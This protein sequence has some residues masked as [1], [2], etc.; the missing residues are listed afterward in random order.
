MISN[1]DNSH[2]PALLSSNQGA[3]VGYIGS[4]NKVDAAMGK[5]VHYKTMKGGK[6]KPKKKSGKKKH[7][8]TAK[9]KHGKKKSGKTAKRKHGKKKS[10]KTAKRKHGKKKKHIGG[11]KNNIPSLLKT[12][13]KTLR[14]TLDYDNIKDL[15][16]S[17]PEDVVKMLVNEP[18]KY[19]NTLLIDAAWEGNEKFV[20]LLI[21]N[22][23]NVNHVAKGGFTPLIAA[24]QNNHFNIVKLLIEKGVNVN[25]KD[26]RNMTALYVAAAYGHKKIVKLLIEKGADVNIQTEPNKHSALMFAASR[27]YNDI[28]KL[29]IEKG[30]DVNA[31]DKNGVSAKVYMNVPID[32]IQS[33]PLKYSSNRHA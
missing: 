22:G 31:Q 17:Y 21:E 15:I 32:V 8:K 26:Q 6:R 33:N 4:S 20:K 7:G 23:A 24:S 10:G 27:G 29:L 16:K 1:P 28:V 11:M 14:K 30:A 5:G 19:G 2:N 12:S 18:D 3:V 25:H 13:L 9:R